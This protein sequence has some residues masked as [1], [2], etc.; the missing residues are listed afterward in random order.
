MTGSSV[1]I[2]IG[3]TTGGRQNAYAV[4]DARLK[5]IR[6]DKA[7]RSQFIEAVKEY[8]GVVCGIQAPLAP[9]KGLMEDIAYRT[10]LGVDSRIAARKNYRVCEYELRKRKIAAY[11]TPPR[12]DAAPFWMQEG[13]ILYDA[14]R[15]E[16]FVDFP[17]IGP[18]RM[19]ETF[20]QAGFAALI[21]KKPY[22]KSGVEGILQ[23]QLI[24]YQ[25]GIDV[26]DPMAVLEEWT[27]HRIMV[28]DLSRRNLYDHD[29]L[30]AIMA[31]YTA[32]KVSRE[33][34]QTVAIGDPTEGQIVLPVP[35]LLESY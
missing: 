9:A 13:W 35:E 27:R 10:R 1:F 28:G 4:L 30:D 25:E 5:V 23:R 29:R 15:R 19:F 8:P 21:K 12:E 31:A 32:F 7:P 16:G 17:R 14:L 3:F 22:T 20:S 24:L 33:P 2:G 18:R 11:S 26:P 6:L 34:D